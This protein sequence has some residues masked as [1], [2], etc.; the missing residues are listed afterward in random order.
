MTPSWPALAAVNSAVDLTSPVMVISGCTVDTSRSKFVTWCPRSSKMA[1]SLV[2]MNPLPPTTK[3][4]IP[5]CTA[6]PVSPQARRDEHTNYAPVARPPTQLPTQT[7]QPQ[8]GSR[9][10]GGEQ[11]VQLLK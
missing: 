10:A 3:I 1:T 7:E 2:P 8:P 9:A 5:A 6:F 4:F 11:V